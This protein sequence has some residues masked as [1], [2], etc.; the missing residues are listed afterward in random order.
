MTNTVTPLNKQ[1]AIAQIN[2]R[3]TALQTIAFLLSKKF[4]KK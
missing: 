2:K 3:P 1:A 4:H